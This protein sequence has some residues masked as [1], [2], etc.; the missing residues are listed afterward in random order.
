[1]KYNIFVLLHQNGR[2]LPN[3]NTQ[4]KGGVSDELSPIYMKNT[5][6]A[7]KALRFVNRNTFDRSQANPNERL[8]VNVPK[9]GEQEVIVPGTLVLCF[10]IDISGR[11]ANNFLVQNLSRALVRKQVVKFRVNTSEYTDGYDVYK[12]FTDLFTDLLPLES[13]KKCCVK[14]FRAKICARSTQ[15][16]GIRDPQE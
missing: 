1:M 7:I 5:G 10:D 3:D 14:V 12:I 13:G 15:T 16:Q 2:D 8:Y 9:L 11:L 4:T 6:K